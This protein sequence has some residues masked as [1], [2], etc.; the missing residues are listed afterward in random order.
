[1][2]IVWGD[3]LK[4][5]ICRKVIMVFLLFGSLFFLN[6]NTPQAKQKPLSGED[7][8]GNKWVYDRET[9]TL[10]FSGTTD[11]EEFELDGH[12]PEPGWWCWNNEAEHLVIENGITG[13]PGEEFSDFYKLKTIEL[14]DTVTYIGHCVFDNCRELK[15][16]NMPKNIISIGNNAFIS[17]HNLQDISIPEKVTTIGEGAFCGCKSIKKLEIP[18]KVTKIGALAFAECENLEAIK[19][20]KDLTVIEEGLFRNCKKLLKVILPTSVKKIQIAAFLGSGITSMEIP[21]NVMS[22]YKGKGMYEYDTNGIFQK[23]KNLKVITIKSKN[24]NYIYKGAFS[25]LSKNTVI[26]VPKSCLKK[27][28]KMF[29]K[30]GLD[31]KVKVK[32]ISGKKKFSP[33]IVKDCPVTKARVTISGHKYGICKVAGNA[34]NK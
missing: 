33:I 8:N 2:E 1:M 27:Y 30:A 29:H 19:L 28:K 10:T 24:L 20:P 25:G 13:L 3:E 11:L 22:F 12:S 26:K 14:P 17:C 21:E 7:Y 5:Q 32:A 9:K 31:K 4:E 6:I 18:E 16:I 34:D 15:T 23:C